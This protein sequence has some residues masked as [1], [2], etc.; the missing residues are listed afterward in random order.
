MNIKTTILSLLLI[1][2]TSAYFVTL[3]DSMKEICFLYYA[4]DSQTKQEITLVA[5]NEYHEN[6]LIVYIEN[7]ESG[8]AIDITPTV[9]SHLTRKYEIHTA[10]YPQIKFCLKSSGKS[11]RTIKVKM[12][13]AGNAVY[14]NKSDLARSQ[15]MMELLQKETKLFSEKVEKEDQKL[16]KQMNSLEKSS[17]YL[18]LVIAAKIYVF[19]ILAVFQ[20]GLFVRHVVEVN[21]ND[22][23]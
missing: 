3:N 16:S 5:V 12:T 13:A 21:K 18:Y 15:K 4:D 7:I 14:T 1:S 23:V 8:S 19:F 17:W 22:L 10:M 20:G 9:I 11:G 6:E 2:L